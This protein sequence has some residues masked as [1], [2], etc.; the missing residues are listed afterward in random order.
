MTSLAEVVAVSK[1][2]KTAMLEG[3]RIEQIFDAINLPG[4]C[5]ICISGL[6][7]EGELSPIS[8]VYEIA[9]IQYDDLDTA[10]LAWDDHHNSQEQRA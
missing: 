3:G 2:R 10:L 9:G 7:D 6:D 5:V 1:L 4:L 8:Q